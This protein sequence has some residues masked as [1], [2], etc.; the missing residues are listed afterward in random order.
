VSRSLADALLGGALTR[1]AAPS[2]PGDDPAG[3]LAILFSTLVNG[4]V[5]RAP[6]PCAGRARGAGDRPNGARRGGAGRKLV[7]QRMQRA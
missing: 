4:I 6:P 7:A 1:A 2:A 5:N 3:Y